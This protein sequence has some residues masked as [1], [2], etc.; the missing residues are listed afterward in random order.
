M[1]RYC[2]TGLIERR[3]D[4]G[5]RVKCWETHETWRVFDAADQHE[6]GRMFLREM[7][8]VRVLSTV[9]QEAEPDPVPAL[10]RRVHELRDCL[11]AM[12]ATEV[13]QWAERVSLD[14]DAVLRE[15]VQVLRQL[16][17]DGEGVGAAALRMVVGAI[18][19]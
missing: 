2:V 14:H 17:L 19:R 4:I 13:R 11:G 8:A 12:P 9:A 5:E 3:E 6:A 18:P 15:T 1:T 16:D 7:G 10:I